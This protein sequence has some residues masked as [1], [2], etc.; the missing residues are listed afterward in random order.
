MNQRRRKAFTLLE[1]QVAIL[2]MA[3]GLMGVLTLM[4]RQ[5]RQ[6]SRLEA[7]CHEDRTYY[8]VPQSNEWMRTLAAPSDLN[9]AAGQPAWTPLVEGPRLFTLT[10]RSSTRTLDTQ[11]ASAEVALTTP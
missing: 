1:L 5:S 2:V 7:W 11:E 4:V 10:L 9:T 8:V 6:V 3:I